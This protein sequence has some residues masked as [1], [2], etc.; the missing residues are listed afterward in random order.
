MKII[1]NEI[2]L[3]DKNLV[4]EKG[5]LANQADASIVVKSGKS[6][7]LVTA[8]AS[9]EN[10]IGSIDYVG[11]S[12]NYQERSYAIGK[13]PGGFTKREG[14][15]DN[16]ILYSRI[17]DRSLRPL[18][19]D[20][21]LAE[22]QIT[23][24]VLSYDPDALSLDVMSIIGSSLALQI[25]GVPCTKS[26]AAKKIIEKGKFKSHSKIDLTISSTREYITMIEAAAEEVSIDILRNIISDV[27]TSLLPILDMMDDFVQKCGNQKHKLLSK[28]DEIKKIC[29]E[30]ISLI[31]NS[32]YLKD[33]EDVLFNSSKKDSNHKIIN[34]R[35]ALLKNILYIHPDANQNIVNLAIRKIEKNLVRRK[36]IKDKKR[37]DG[38]QSHEIRH[39]S[40]ITG[41][42]P[43]SHGS[44][45]FTRGDT[46][47]LAAVTLGGS[48][49]EQI[50]D[51]LNGVY[52]DNLIIHYNF[53]SFATNEIGAARSPGRREIGH[54]NLA[55]KSLRSL[56]PLKEQG[57]FGYTTRV[58]AEVLS[59]NGSSSMATV[60][61][62]SLAMRDAGVP[63]LKL[64]GGI[65]MGLIK[66]SD[67]MM[68]L[69][70]ITGNED[71]LGD[72]DFKI[73]GTIDG[74]TALQMDIK[75]PLDNSIIIGAINQSSDGLKHIINIMN[76]CERKDTNINFESSPK[77]KNVTI[78]ESL[79]KK[80]IG[81]GGRVIKDICE[82]SGAKIEVNNSGIIS[83]MAPNQNSMKFVEDYIKE[84]VDGPKIG[85]ICDGIISKIAEFGLFIRFGRAYEGLVHISEIGDKYIDS[86]S[87]IFNID[88]QIK[89]KVIE[90]EK[91]GKIR[92]KI[93]NDD[94]C[95]D[96][97]I[98]DNININKEK[99]DSKNL[100][101]KNKDVNCSTN[102][103]NNNSINNQEIDITNQNS[104]KSKQ[105]KKVPKLLN[106]F[107][108][109]QNTTQKT[110]SGKNEKDANLVDSSKGEKKIK[111]YQNLDNNS[112][113]SNSI[114]YKEKQDK[115]FDKVI[116][117]SNISV[118]I[119]NQ[120]N[121]ENSNESKIN[122][123]YKNTNGH[124]KRRLRFF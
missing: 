16:D 1:S 22:V 94:N 66:E 102:A 114:K 82:K 74:I 43:S 86:L 98:N 25:S 26:V 55:Y 85:L 76:S 23:V 33:F 90:I 37:I 118:D 8:V 28:V 78:S 63:I 54:G 83:I 112:N 95:N 19:D 50:K 72:M 56:I 34:I 24:N 20:H 105:K 27:Q 75:S 41:Y 7:I 47:V 119:N 100:T 69:S 21:Y 9:H 89:I 14:K 103:I 111:I 123:Q 42:L 93:V 31:N 106:K 3:G 91:S 117:N 60:C 92:L 29:N 107:S 53:P 52:Y 10:L 32:D 59:S 109:K 115:S 84:L 64:V 99:N 68:I 113:T 104:L 116:D 124:Q 81:P 5:F 39:I 48:Q 110:K 101:S 17:I 49:D 122:I 88:Q 77:V 4:V 2:K 12:V 79:V 18:I 58:V 15:T 36:V 108:S 87:D 71:S 46:Q 61:A 35:E 121:Q 44:A 65:A 30:Y 51:S 73:S 97:N 40:C 13:I 96:L 11:L 45:I 70:D 57:R 6:V 62:S 38:R 80:I 67:N 120:E